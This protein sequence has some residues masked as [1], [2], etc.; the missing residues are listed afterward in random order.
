MGVVV[1]VV[2]VNG[3]TSRLAI[4][5]TSKLDTGFKVNLLTSF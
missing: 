2:V 4:T 1:N 3:G 5:T